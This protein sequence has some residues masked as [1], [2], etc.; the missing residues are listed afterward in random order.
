MAYLSLFEDF[1]MLFL[2]SSS[3]LVQLFL[4]WEGV[5]LT[6]Y[7]LI[8]FWNYKE[9]ANKAALKAFIVNR[10]GDVGLLLDYLPF[11]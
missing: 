6:S 10:I 2:V 8:G 3:N 7:L 9:Q 5:G 4:G 1:F 11:L